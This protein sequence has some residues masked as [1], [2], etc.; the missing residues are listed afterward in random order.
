[1]KKIYNIT[2]E[3]L[4]KEYVEN[5]KSTRQIAKIIGCDSGTILRNLKKYNIKIRHKKDYIGENSA[6]FKHGETLKKHFC[7]DCGVEL[8]N[9]KS[10]R[11]P[12]CAG[13]KCSKVKKLKYKDP[14]NHPSFID[15]SSIIKHYCITE[16]CNNEISY[17]CWWRGSKLC[18]VC[19]KKL[20]R[21]KKRPNHSKRMTG[22]KN[23]AYIH[24]LS[25]DY[26]IEFNKE[27]KL[28]IR[29]RDNYTCQ[30]CSITEEEHIIVY[31]KVLCAHHIDYN[32]KN[33]KETNLTTLCQECNVRV[34]YNRDYW[35]EFFQTLIR[36]I[37]VQEKK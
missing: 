29:K 35:K 20:R 27:L 32:K 24:G 8:G 26:P 1:M 2:K 28:K 4:L 10:K 9:Y 11:C 14:R 15:G 34:N 12:K 3:Y 16:E 7:I 21:G 36:R 37:Y 25:S 5:F 23:P 30:K 18:S 33:C 31:G 13:I 6:S 19:S 17:S 22:D